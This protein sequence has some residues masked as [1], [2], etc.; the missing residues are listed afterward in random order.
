MYLQKKP[1]VSILIAIVAVLGLS[2]CGKDLS[3]LEKRVKQDPFEATTASMVTMA[4]RPHNIQRFFLKTN[5]SENY[6][7]MLEP[8]QPAVIRTGNTSLM[9]IALTLDDGWN[10][11]L[12]L[13]DLFKSYNIKFTA[14]LIGERGICDIQP[15][16]L[17]AIQGAGGEICNHSATHSLMQ[18]RDPNF[19]ID[20]IWRAQNNITRVTGRIYPYIRFLGGSYDDTSVNTAAAEGFYVVNWNLSIGD[21][22]VGNTTDRQIAGVLNGLSPGSII[23]CHW[24]GYNTYDVL[25]VLIPEMQRRGYEVTSLTGVLEGTPYVLHSSL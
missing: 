18:G 9:R 15:E 20:Q 7:G 16:F 8:V 6:R 13:L 23:L 10:A 21:T 4:K 22:V 1:I 12:R 2:G 17:R 25:S 19:I 24:G 14:F 11:D 3:S 5:K